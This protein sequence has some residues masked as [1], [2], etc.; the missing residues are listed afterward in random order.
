LGSRHGAGP[1]VSETLNTFFPDARGVIVPVPVHPDWETVTDPF[2][3]TL[4]EAFPPVETIV[5][6]L[7]ET[8][9]REAAV[10]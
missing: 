1:N 3:A 10:L 8:L 9:L 6:Q 2:A 4:M 5:F 7:P